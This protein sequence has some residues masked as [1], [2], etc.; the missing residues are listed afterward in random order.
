MSISDQA[1]AKFARAR[2]F[3]HLRVDRGMLGSLL[4]A[5]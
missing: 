3:L 2:R 1:R 5:G 4:A